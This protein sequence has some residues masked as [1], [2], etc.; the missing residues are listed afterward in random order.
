MQKSNTNIFLILFLVFC[1]TLSAQ[2]LRTDIEELKRINITEHLGE[3]IPLDVE[4]ID[5]NGQVVLLKEYFNSGKPVILSFAYYECQ[6]LCAQ[7][8]NSL[9]TSINRFDWDSEDKY[10]IVTIS[11]DARDKPESAAL[12]K[13][14]YVAGLDDTSLM[15]NWNFF[16]ASQATID[17]LTKAIGFEYY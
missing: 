8:L 11:I 3:E 15:Y 12:K 13:S 4:I 1:S 17:T 9:S 14:R 10:S 16:T 5:Q 7:V 6:M 2:R